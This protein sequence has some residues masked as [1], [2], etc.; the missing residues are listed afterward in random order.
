MGQE[1]RHKKINHFNS[2]FSETSGSSFGDGSSSNWSFGVGRAT[3]TGC[4]HGNMH[5]LRRSVDSHGNHQHQQAQQQNHS[6]IKPSPLAF[7]ANSNTPPHLFNILPLRNY[8]QPHSGPD[9][10]PNEDT[11]TATALKCLFCSKY[12]EYS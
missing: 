10:R 2:F 11:T 8:V 6:V 1:R 9:S 12:I 7:E 4:G 3:A 5:S